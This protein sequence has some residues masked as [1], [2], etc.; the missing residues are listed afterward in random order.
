MQKIRVTRFECFHISASWKSKQQAFFYLELDR[1]GTKEEQAK[2][3]TLANL[4]T[5]EKRKEKHVYH[6]LVEGTGYVWRVEASIIAKYTDRLELPCTIEEEIARFKREGIRRPSEKIKVN[7]VTIHDIEKPHI[8]SLQ[9]D[10]S[11]ETLHRALDQ[12]LEDHWQ[13]KDD[14]IHVGTYGANITITRVILQVFLE[15]FSFERPLG[16][17]LKEAMKEAK[18]ATERMKQ[19]R[20]EQ[21]ERE[22]EREQKEKDDFYEFIRR[23]FNQ[24]SHSYS[25]SRSYRYKAPSRTNELSVTEALKTFGLHS[26]ATLQDVK[27][28]YRV[29]AKQHH[30][31]TGGDEEIFKKINAANQVLM[32]Y[33]SR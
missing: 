25:Y 2:R 16:E 8:I 1:D 33:F 14:W 22:K 24:Q 30:P 3:K 5:K 31:D 29:L 7:R 12:Y 26:T 19:Y 20:K 10:E 28:R 17:M 13:S 4:L 9:L 32:E 27:K 23:H 21:R 18:E 11:N 6:Q 15:W